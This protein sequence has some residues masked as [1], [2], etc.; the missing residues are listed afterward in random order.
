VRRQLYY[1]DGFGRARRVRVRTRSS[2]PGMT[3]FVLALF[4]VLIVLASIPR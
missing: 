4:A 1:R 3:L 2:L